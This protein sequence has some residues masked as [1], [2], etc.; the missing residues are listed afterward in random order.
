M[1]PDIFV[2]VWV[3]CCIAVAFFYVIRLRRTKSVYVADFQAGLR[4]RGGR[5]CTILRPGSYRSS[6]SSDPITLVDLRPYP[7]LVERLMFKDALRTHAVISVAG[8]FTVRNPEL[9]FT[10]FKNLFDDSL[11]VIRQNL[12]PAASRLIADPSADG[13]AKMTVAI[14]SELNRE[15]NT[16]GVEIQSLEITELYVRPLIETVPAAAN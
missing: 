3:L 9:A 8:D 11:S 1:L 15:L 12:L 5:G 6:R 13:L 10:S 16:R 7:F 14:T 4:F 2:Q